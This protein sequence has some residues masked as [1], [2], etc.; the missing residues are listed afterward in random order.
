MKILLAF[1]VLTSSLAAQ[2]TGVP[3]GRSEIRRVLLLAREAA[4]QEERDEEGATGGSLPQRLQLLMIGFRSID[5]RQE[6][7]LS[8]FP[9]GHYLSSPARCSL[10]RFSGRSTRR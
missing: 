2:Q 10:P 4:L 7:S 8:E 9:Y 1:L 3:F 6:G 5:D